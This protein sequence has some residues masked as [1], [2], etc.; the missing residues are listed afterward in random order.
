MKLIVSELTSETPQTPFDANFDVKGIVFKAS[1]ASWD[2]S[3]VKL[4]CDAVCFCFDRER[5]DVTLFDM[6]VSLPLACLVGKAY[7]TFVLASTGAL[8]DAKVAAQNL[9]QEDFITN[10]G[11]ES[12]ARF[13]AGAD[14][15]VKLI[16]AKC[17]TVVDQAREICNKR[18]EECEKL[19]NGDAHLKEFFANMKAPTDAKVPT[20]E[21]V[22]DDV[23]LLIKKGS[24]AMKFTKAYFDYK[25][26]WEVYEKQCA[27]LLVPL[28]SDVQDSFKS[29]VN[30]FEI[31]TAAQALT[32]PLKTGE[33]RPVLL[34]QLEAVVALPNLPMVL[35][36]LI[37]KEVPDMAPK[38][39]AAA[40]EPAAAVPVE[41]GT[42][43]AEP[44]A[45]VPVELGTATEL[46]GAAKPAVG[47]APL[48]PV[49]ADTGA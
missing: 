5:K 36:E 32:R 19:R 18:C 43:T 7:R 24:A 27:T 37:C 9:S 15:L 45:A 10:F 30:C 4:C 39:R 8:V 34:R 14:N 46:A 49:V 1:V 29:A 23:K 41:L 38:F 33:S 16:Q 40:A 35:S 26:A 11:N 28:I 13:K 48:P 44:A 25:K 3:K 22:T 20:L 31:L 21:S 42:A 47:E 12:G 2:D 6:H 17:I